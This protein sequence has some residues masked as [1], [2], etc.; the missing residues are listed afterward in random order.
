[1]LLTKTAICT[2]LD[3]TMKARLIVFRILLQSA[4]R[5]GITVASKV[6]QRRGYSV[7]IEN[8]SQYPAS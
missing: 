5:S 8:F 3:T 2:E 7:L 6:Y 4:L 1:M